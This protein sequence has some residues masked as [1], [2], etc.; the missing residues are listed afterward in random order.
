LG[1]AINWNV[2][3][4]LKPWAERKARSRKVPLQLLAKGF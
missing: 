1:R 4:P 3:D 2:I